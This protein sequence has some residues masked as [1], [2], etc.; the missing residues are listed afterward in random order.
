VMK[1]KKKLILVRAV[2][3]E[4]IFRGLTDDQLETKS[5]SLQSDFN[6]GVAS[7]TTDA[8]V[9]ERPVFNFQSANTETHWILSEDQCMWKISFVTNFLTHY[10]SCDLL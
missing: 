8:L 6:S 9:T 1:N 4:S 7:P 3:E 2:I 10:L 5:D